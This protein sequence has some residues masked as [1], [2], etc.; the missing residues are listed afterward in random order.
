MKPFAKSSFVAPTIVGLSHLIFTGFEV[1]DNNYW[2]TNFTLLNVFFLDKVAV[3]RLRELYLQLVD[4]FLI[5]RII[6]THYI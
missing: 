1:T 5:R 3:L 2:S 4:S 6:Q